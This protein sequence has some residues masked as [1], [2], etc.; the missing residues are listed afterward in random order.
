MA[1]ATEKSHLINILDKLIDNPGNTEDEETSSSD[2]ESTG[3]NGNGKNG[4]I[5]DRVT[6]EPENDSIQVLSPPPTVSQ[7]RKRGPRPKSDIYYVPIIVVLTS[8]QF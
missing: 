3:S 2:S 4:T 6:P 5:I 1:H 8:L 7:K